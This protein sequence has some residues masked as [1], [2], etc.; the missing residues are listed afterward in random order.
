L[1]SSI[2]TTRGAISPPSSNSRKSP[3]EEAFI[4]AQSIDFGTYE[5]Q[6]DKVQENLAVADLELHEARIDRIDVEGVLGFAEHLIANAARAWMEASLEQRQQIQSAIFPE[7]LPFDG[8]E[9][10]TA[11]T[12][13]AFKQ[14][15]KSEGL[16]NEMASPPGFDHFLRRETT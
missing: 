7:G 1:A 4:Y 11:P 10:G 13:L 14:L 12:C 16:Q 5:R 2:A 15:G 9:F 8:R 3:V 6:R